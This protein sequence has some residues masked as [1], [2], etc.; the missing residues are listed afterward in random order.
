MKKF[1]L[2]NLTIPRRTSGQ[3]YDGVQLTAQQ[4]QSSTIGPACLSQDV[5]RKKHAL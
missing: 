2:A 3:T 1:T 4:W 5:D